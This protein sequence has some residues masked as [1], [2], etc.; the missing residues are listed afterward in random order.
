MS[1]TQ[2]DPRVLSAENYRDW[3]ELWSVERMEV[4]PDEEIL[5]GCN[6]Y[7]LKT[8]DDY[9]LTYH[10][11]HLEESLSVVPM[12][13]RLQPMFEQKLVDIRNGTIRP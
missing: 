8:K 2:P 9:T 7:L 1:I 11:T 3:M 4:R 5:G 13:K 10:V 12:W 6:M